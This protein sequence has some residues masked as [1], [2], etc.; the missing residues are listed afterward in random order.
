MSIVG[1]RVVYTEGREYTSREHTWDDLPEV[2][3]VEGCIYRL[4][5]DGEVRRELWGGS[6]WY[7]TDDESGP[8]YR[9]TVLESGTSRELP[10]PGVPASRLKAGRWVSDEEFVRVS[11]HLGGS[12]PP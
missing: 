12:D 9:G 11:R 7:W 1:W 5:P 4:D 2:G 3:W 8:W 6:D 10:P